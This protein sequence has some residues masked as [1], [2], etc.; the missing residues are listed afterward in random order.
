MS[1]IYVQTWAMWLLGLLYVQLHVTDPSQHAGLQHPS[2][3]VRV[4][5]SYPMLWGF[6]TKVQKIIWHA[7]GIC[8]L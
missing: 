5:P 6:Q 2:A 8:I 1:H 7:L 4:P 3:L